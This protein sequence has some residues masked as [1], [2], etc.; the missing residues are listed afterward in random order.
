MKVMILVSGKLSWDLWFPQSETKQATGRERWQ[1][2]TKWLKKDL[3]KLIKMIRTELL[4][5]Q[6]LKTHKNDT[7]WVEC[8]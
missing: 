4:I 5:Q 7:V 8:F 2:S 3:Q 6:H 1:I